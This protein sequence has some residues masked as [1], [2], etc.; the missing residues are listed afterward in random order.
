IVN[1][2]RW[3][4]HR[5]DPTIDPAPKSLNVARTRTRLAELLAHLGGIDARLAREL[6][7]D[8]EAL[9]GR[10][11]VLEKEIT[12]LVQ[13]QAPALLELP[14]CA[15]LTAAKIVGETAGIDRFAN[16]AKYAMHTGVAPIPV[17]SGS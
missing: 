5:L 14:G 10:I 4:L 13:A 7:A 9:T 17:W 12:A 16:E 3:H 11:N 15:A 6:L 1:R 2:F 8:I